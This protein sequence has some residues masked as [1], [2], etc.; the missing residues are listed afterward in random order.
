M[1][2]TVSGDAAPPERYDVA[3]VAFHWTVA[4]LIVFLGALG[5]LFGEIPRDVRPFWINVHGC[6]GLVYFALVLA[7]L[8]WRATHNPPHL[9]AGMGELT[10]RASGVAHGLLYLL[11]LAIPVLGVVAFVWH[12]RAFDFGLFRIDFG[13]A[14]DR[15]IFHPAEQVHQLLAYA[16]FALA[17]LHA[18]AALYHQYV[19][20]DRLL[21]RMMPGGAQ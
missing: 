10:R 13:V 8:A 17:G 19:R 6:V 9:P 14:S 21:L 20:R 15:T 7:R 1:R 16:L 11:M 4:A 2:N 5:L 12:G 18:A 3:A